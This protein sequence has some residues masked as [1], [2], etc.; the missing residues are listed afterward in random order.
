MTGQTIADT[1][2][3]P[4]PAPAKLNLLL[5]INGRRPDGYHELQSLFQF[6]TYAD[7]LYFDIRSDGA[8]DLAGTPGGVA[9]E[10]DLTVRAARLLQARS[11]CRLGVGIHLDKRLPIGAGLG[12]G[13]SD[14]ATTLLVLNR[15]WEINLEI[16]ELANI[17]LQ[18]GAD[19]PVFVQGQAAA[20]AGVGE[21]LTPVDLPEPWYLV[22]DPCVSV[23]TAEIF[24][25]AELTRDT[26]KQTIADLLS[27]AGRND[28]EA[29]VCARYPEV[30]AALKWLNNYV[31]ARMTGTGSCVFGAFEKEADAQMVA[32]QVPDR[33]NGLVTRGVNRSP[34]HTALI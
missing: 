20:A 33:W 34:L 8:I 27:D 32:G 22:L 16:N 24:S 6:L 7:S 2:S 11:G 14:A 13:S 1:A 12:G 19:V 4:W 23:S 28:C 31:P 3:G 30:A 9:A 18:L 25:D 26:P 29:V 10:Q 21:H 17:G 15:L 5:H